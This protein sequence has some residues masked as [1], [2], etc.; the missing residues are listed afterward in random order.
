MRGVHYVPNPGMV[1]GQFRRPEMGEPFIAGEGRVRLVKR[2]T[3]NVVEGM[4]LLLPAHNDRPPAVN[5]IIE[6][7]RLRF[8]IWTDAN[9][10]LFG[11]T[12]DVTPLAITQAYYGTS[13]PVA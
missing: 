11:A 7:A 4:I 10:K 9:Q 5:D 12:L 6:T 3:D 1:N 13:K 2:K 8:E